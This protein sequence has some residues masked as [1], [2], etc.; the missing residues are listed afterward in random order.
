MG[1]TGSIRIAA[2]DCLTPL[3]NA[4]RTHAALMRGERALRP[5]PVL[6][7]DGGDLVPLAL[8]PGRTLDETT[9]PDWLQAMHTLL[10]PLAG[11]GWGG[12]RRP[13]FFTSSNFGVGSLHAFRRSG[14]PAHAAYGTPATSIEQIRHTLDWGTHFAI[15]SHACVSAHLGLLQATRMIQ[16]GLADSALVVSYVFLSPFVAGGFHSL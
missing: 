8:L 4:A 14:D 1:A 6:G 2:C 13:V 12:P 7:R 11:D 9:P 5:T 16:A 10:R 15:F 3:G